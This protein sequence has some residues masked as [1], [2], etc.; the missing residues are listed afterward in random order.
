MH[1][2]SRRLCEKSVPLA[3]CS[4]KS[5]RVARSVLA[6]EAIALIE[7]YDVGCSADTVYRLI[8]LKQ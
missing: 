1:S 8:Q 2:T 4:I 5:R 6:A 3:Y 7:A